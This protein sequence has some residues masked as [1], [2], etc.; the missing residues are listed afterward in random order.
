M[1]DAQRP[2]QASQCNEGKQLRPDLA[3]SSL[4]TG[5]PLWAF[6]LL[7]TDRALVK[8]VARTCALADNRGS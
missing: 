1:T 5:D 8:T 4:H 7:L 6:A 3:G 2:S